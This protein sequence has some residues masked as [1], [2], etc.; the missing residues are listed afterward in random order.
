MMVQTRISFPPNAAV[1]NRHQLT[2]H[3]MLSFETLDRVFETTSI[4]TD[5][6][7][8]DR[9]KVHIL[10]PSCDYCS[11]FIDDTLNFTLLAFY[12]FRVEFWRQN[13]PVITATVNRTNI[14]HSPNQLLIVATVAFK[15]DFVFA[16]G[17]PDARICSA[18]NTAPNQLSAQRPPSTS[19][20]SSAGFSIP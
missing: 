17:S 8:I 6:N 18:V 2:S 4:V 20:G 19:P 1:A 5:L 16:A 3:I 13:L 15:N 9:I 11:K 12:L 14:N 10:L 7:P